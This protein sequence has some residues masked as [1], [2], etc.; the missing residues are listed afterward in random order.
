MSQSIDQYENIPFIK[1][2]HRC[3]SLESVSVLHKLSMCSPHSLYFSHSS[4]HN[5]L[6]AR[7]SCALLPSPNAKVAAKSDFG[8]ATTSFNY[9]TDHRTGNLWI[10]WRREKINNKA[11][12]K[13]PG[14]IP[15]YL[16]SLNFIQ[17]VHQF[18]LTVTKFT[19]YVVK[20]ISRLG[21]P[22]AQKG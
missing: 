13:F 17:D 15:C 4:V 2:T 14:Y 20:L 5:P 3:S 12:T 19:T 21:L 16:V 10:I 8:T 1:S 18:K 7:Y 22:F 9:G 11:A 6:N